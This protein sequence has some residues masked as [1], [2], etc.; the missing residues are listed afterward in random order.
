MEL[1][2]HTSYKL[3]DELLSF[4]HTEKQKEFCGLFCN[5]NWISKLAH[6]AD[7][8]GHLN[9]INFNMQSKNENLLSSTDKIRALKEK[10]KVWSL[11]VKNGTC[12]MLYHFSEKKTKK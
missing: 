1:F 7:I 10:V 3:K 6:L 8:F 5:D 12:K 2:G 11:K 9:N 4:F